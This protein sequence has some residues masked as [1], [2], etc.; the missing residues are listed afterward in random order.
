MGSKSITTVFARQ[1]VQEKLGENKTGNTPPTTTPADRRGG[2]R[3]G[4]GREA[5]T[6]LH[7]TA[8]ATHRDGPCPGP[9]QENHPRSGHG[10]ERASRREPAPHPHGAPRC[11]PSG[12]DLDTA[13]RTG[14]LDTA[15]RTGH[16][17]LT[18]QP[19]DQTAIT[20]TCQF[21][22]AIEN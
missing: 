21:P 7:T 18:S 3:P 4:F 16:P 15:N 19:I 14:H 12:V 6:A 5:G 10:R 20:T 13:N 17:D 2:P 22:E 9:G 1:R 8:L 11:E